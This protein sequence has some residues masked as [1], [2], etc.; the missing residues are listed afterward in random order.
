MWMLA[1]G[2]LLCRLL[3]VILCSPFIIAYFVLKYT[4]EGLVYLWYIFWEWCM[5]VW[6]SAVSY[7]KGVGNELW[8]VLM[9]GVEWCG[10]FWDALW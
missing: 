6:D 8:E 3:L 2:G 4:Y 9:K 7:C 10:S 5:S 1:F